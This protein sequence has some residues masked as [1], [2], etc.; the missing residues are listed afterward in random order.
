MKVFGGVAEILMAC[1]PVSRVQVTCEYEVNTYVH[2]LSDTSAPP[3]W[4]L[5]L[6]DN[7][8]LGEVSDHS[9]I[10]EQAELGLAV[11]SAFVFIVSYTHLDD[12][13]DVAALKQIY[14]KDSRKYLLNY[15]HHPLPP[16]IDH[17]SYMIFF[18]GGG[19]VHWMEKKKVKGVM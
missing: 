5:L 1:L 7:P 11:G 16:P 8:G 4:T 19:V 14:E 9:R 12:A 2:C 17:L 13:E 3:S 10:M 15:P 6:V 18:W